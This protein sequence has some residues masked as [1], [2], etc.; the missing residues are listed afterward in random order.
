VIADYVYTVDEALRTL[1][2]KVHLTIA[3]QSFGDDEL[4]ILKSTVVRFPGEREIVFHWKQNG[5]VAFVVRSHGHAVTPDIE[6]L[7]ELKR[8]RGVEHVEVSL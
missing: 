8:I 1:G 5:N 4:D 3:S 6:L 7:S 2:R